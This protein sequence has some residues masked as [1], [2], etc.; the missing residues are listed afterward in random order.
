MR[1]KYKKISD[2][3]DSKYRENDWIYDH[4][5]VESDDESE[6]SS[7]NDWSSLINIYYDSKTYVDET[8]EQKEA[9]LAKEKAEK[10]N[11]KIDQILGDDK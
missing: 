6:S 3:F 7:Y 10:R 11:N 9:R 2:Y 4:F 8:E 5:G 1:K